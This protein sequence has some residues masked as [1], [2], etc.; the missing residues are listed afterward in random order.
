MRVM[1]D[2][3]YNVVDMFVMSGDVSY[4]MSVSTVL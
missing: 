3:L 1:C 4:A 2:R